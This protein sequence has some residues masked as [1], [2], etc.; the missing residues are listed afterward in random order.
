MKINLEPIFN[1]DSLLIFVLIITTLIV[2]IMFH[3]SPR[4]VFTINILLIALYFL[5]SRID[6]KLKL[7]LT[8]IHFSIWGVFIESFIIKKTSLLK[9][10]NISYS[11]NFP[12]W[13]FPAYSI[14][15]LGGLYTYKIIDKIIVFS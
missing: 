6:N 4:L 10:K 7:L 3:R 11:L 13:L 12:L 15:L 2:L 9:Y 1:Y 14:F 5:I 8:M